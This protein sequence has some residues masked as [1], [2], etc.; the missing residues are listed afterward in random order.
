MFV[1][2]A[3]V[4][5]SICSKMLIHAGWSFPA[6]LGDFRQLLARRLHDGAGR[7][8]KANREYCFYVAAEVAYCP[9]AVTS[10]SYF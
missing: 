5:I 6:P 9:N 2:C 4:W 10:V 7:K 3:G 1:E 8:F